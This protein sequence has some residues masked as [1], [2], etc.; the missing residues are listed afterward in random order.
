M[1]TFLLAVVGLALSCT[2]VSDR[3]PPMEYS[4]NQNEGY[5][6]LYDLMSKQKNV[7]KLLMIKKEKPDVGTVV[8]RIAA[9][10][11]NA[12][13]KMESF[14]TEDPSLNLE[15]KSLPAVEQATR[16]SIE[17]ERTKELLFSTGEDFEVHLLLSQAEGICY[18]A[19]L[20]GVLASE[21]KHNGRKEYMKHLSKELQDLQK[22]VIEILSS[23]YAPPPAADVSTPVATKPDEK[24]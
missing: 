6:L 13:Q 1:F 15:V 12:A 20:A 4:F 11:T 18:G 24:P 10:C 21:E 16:A 3:K 9:T 23:R 17:S 2:T 7:D 8:E 19:H 22:S 14:R 5:S